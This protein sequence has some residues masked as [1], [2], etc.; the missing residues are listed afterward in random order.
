MGARLTLDERAELDRLR[1]RVE[2]QADLISAWEA[3]GLGGTRAACGGY[4][5]LGLPKSPA[6]VLAKLVSAAGEVV[7]KQQLLQASEAG[8]IDPAHVPDEAIIK[9]HIHQIRRALRA[10]GFGNPIKPY[11]PVGYL[12]TCDG[13]RA[14]LDRMTPSSDVELLK[15]ARLVSEK[16]AVGKLQ[17]A[18]IDELRRAIRNVTTSATDLAA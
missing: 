8:R 9:V 15:A 3:Y 14:L 16:H 18:H 10:H 11:R 5:S 1:R 17:P 6:L 7:P 2:E 13:A 4:A 12:I